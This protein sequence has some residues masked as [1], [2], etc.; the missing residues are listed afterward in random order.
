ML[1]WYMSLYPLDF[2]RSA[3][4]GGCLVPFTDIEFA[5]EYQIILK[6][7]ESPT[8]AFLACQDI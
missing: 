6:P 3:K 8:L 4:R 2:P 5:K 7:G 1:L